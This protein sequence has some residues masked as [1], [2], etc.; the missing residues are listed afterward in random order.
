MPVETVIQLLAFLGALIGVWVAL[1]SRIVRLEVSIEH[2]DK[3]FD[4]I[5][6]HLRRI[7]DKLDGKADRT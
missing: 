6:A 5:V 2:S 1:N 4:Q 7:E 3:Q